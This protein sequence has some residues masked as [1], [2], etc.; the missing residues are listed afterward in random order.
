MHLCM[1]HI[2]F[3]IKVFVISVYSISGV[4]SL[5]I[6]DKPSLLDHGLVLYSFSDVIVLLAYLL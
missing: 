1:L 5:N 6:D 2:L 4:K 3:N